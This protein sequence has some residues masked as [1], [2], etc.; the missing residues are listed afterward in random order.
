MADRRKAQIEHDWALQ[1]HLMALMA[2]INR[3]STKK[4]AP[5][6]PDDFNPMKFSPSESGKPTDEDLTERLERLK[7]LF[8]DGK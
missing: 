2:N 3:D 7:K 8:P 6:V 4:P 5:F 1:S